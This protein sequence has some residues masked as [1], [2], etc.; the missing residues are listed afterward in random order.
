MFVSIRVTVRL[1]LLFEIGPLCAVFLSCSLPGS[2]PELRV[3]LP[4][5]P[6]A[7]VAALGEGEWSLRWTGSDGEWH[8]RDGF[9]SGDTVELSIDEASAILAYPYWPRLGIVCGIARPAGAIHPFDEED[10]VLFLDWNGGP[11]AHFFRELEGA[12]GE[13]QTKPE[14]FDW[15]RFRE[16]LYGDLVAAEVSADPWVVDW[17]LVAE[18]TRSSGFDR[19][20]L[21]PKPTDPLELAVPAAGPWVAASPFAASPAWTGGERV[22]ITASAEADSFLCAA[23]VLRYSMGLIAWF[24]TP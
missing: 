21:V 8:C 14:L 16:L 9:L 1:L 5:L 23:G 6:D 15:P 22:T 11:V 10:G 20:R 19:R 17:R 2:Q 24:P 12:G 3:Q 18:K 4:A 7:W 13:A